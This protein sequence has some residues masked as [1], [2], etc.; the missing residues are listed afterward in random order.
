M[1]LDRQ[2]SDL[3]RKAQDGDRLA[4]EA[5]LTVVMPLV[6]A[7]TRTRL[8]DA[9]G[10][11]D[12]AQE[13]LLAI[14]RD[15]HTWDPARPFLPWMYAIARNRLLDLIAKRCRQRWNEIGGDAALEDV[16]SVEASADR[17]PV[18]RFLRRALAMLSTKQRDVIQMLKFEGLSVADIS[19]KTGMSASSVKVTAHR[20]YKA[21]RRLIGERGW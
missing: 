8:P 4:Y 2:L 11:E 7:F 19:L 17:D 14:H 21:L 18:N 13:T 5:L 1:A 15:R 16:A 12:V 9:D 3:M 6:R 20:G 10:V